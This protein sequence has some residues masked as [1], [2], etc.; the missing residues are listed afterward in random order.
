MRSKDTEFA[1]TYIGTHAQAHM[2]DQ[3]TRG[4]ATTRHRSLVGK[5]G[6]KAFVSNK[7][8]AHKNNTSGKTDIS[9]PKQIWST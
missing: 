4:M 5:S 1:R 2:Y 9:N 8:L 6:R 7:G 3:R